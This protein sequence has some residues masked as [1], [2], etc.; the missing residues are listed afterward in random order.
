MICRCCFYLTHIFEVSR[1]EVLISKFFWACFQNLQICMWWGLEGLNT[2]CTMSLARPWT[3]TIQSRVV[4]HC[5]H[6]CSFIC[7]CIDFDVVT[8]FDYMPPV[9]FVIRTRSIWKRFQKWSISKRYG[10]IGCVNG[11]TISIKKQ[12]G[13]KLAGSQ[14]VVFDA[15]SRSW[16]HFHWKLRLC[17]RSLN[18]SSQNCH[19]NLCR[20]HFDLSRMWRP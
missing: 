14:G 16:N 5:L 3:W 6:G 7:N 18:E 11:K 10:F 12:S 13:V 15:V 9:K 8:P 20:S 1:F 19:T 17:K 2:L 4:R